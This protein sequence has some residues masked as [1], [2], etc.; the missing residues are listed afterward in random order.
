[1]KWWNRFSQQQNTF[2]MISS[3]RSSV[4]HHSQIYPELQYLEQLILFRLE[5]GSFP[6]SNKLAPEMP[7]LIN[8]KLPVKDFI[9]RW[10]LNETESIL[11]LIALT[12]HVL[13]DLFD[14]VVESKMEK[15]ANLPK[16]GG[17]RGKNSR[18]FLPTGETVLF[19]LAGDDLDLRLKIQ[20]F[21]SADHLFSQRKIVWLEEIPF[22]EPE[23]SGRLIVSH[24]FI[25][26]FLFGRSAAPHFS[27]SFPAKKI[28]EQR[29]WDSLVINSE[30]QGQL[31]EIMNWLHYNNALIEDWG[32]EDRIKKGYR[33]LFY[34]QPGT[35][36]T[37]T[38]A[39]LGK[40]VGRDVF[41]VDLSMVVSKFIGETEKNLELLFSRAEDKG[42]ILFFD[43]ADALFGKRTSIGNAH[44]KYANQ[45]VSYLLQRIEDYNGLIILAT[46]M[47][48]NIDEAFVRRFNVIIR[49]PFP[50]ADER[51]EIWKKSFPRDIQFYSK[52]KA[53]VDDKF[54]EQIKK[55]E[56]AGGSI[57]N[58]VHYACLKAI[59]RNKIKEEN[60]TIDTWD[61]EN[62]LVHT[63]DVLHGIQVELNKYGKPFIS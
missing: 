23:M 3:E 34:G 17:V 26:Q 54:G 51:K 24:D 10:Q 4:N 40:E 42:W 19:L 63:S 60:L 25:Q 30:L 12:P 14:R 48:N 57:V 8:W 20:Q 62:L 32:M 55:Y 41:K 59:E 43:E 39:I 46:N 27:T 6:G 22:G 49:F 1:M 33:A 29:S 2:T 37:L 52:A 13:P 5:D 11:L 9:H 21:F 58:V 50:E 18:G 28:N 53:Q 35:G 31:Q 16:L 45:E 36:K 47:K 56:L 38:A 15:P 7:S 44:D 61:D